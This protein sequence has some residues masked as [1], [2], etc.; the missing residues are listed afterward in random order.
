[1]TGDLK[2]VGE[3]YW[4]ARRVSE[5]AGRIVM[6]FTGTVPERQIQALFNAR[7]VTV[8]QAYAPKIADRAR[9]TGLP[10]PGFDQRPDRR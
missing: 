5:Q 6:A 3:V 8:Y 10:A 4:Q 9:R 1:M 2:F 7:T